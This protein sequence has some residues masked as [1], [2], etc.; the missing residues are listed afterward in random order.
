MFGVMGPLPSV[1]LVFTPPGKGGGLLLLLP[2][3]PLLL[4]R[5]NGGSLEA[6]MRRAISRLFWVE[7]RSFSALDLCKD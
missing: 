7:A 3:P 6:T 5:S 1:I 2:P 4:E